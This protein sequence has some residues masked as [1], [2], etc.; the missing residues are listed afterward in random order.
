MMLLNPTG[1]YLAVAGAGHVIVLELPQEYNM[2]TF[3]SLK[4]IKIGREPWYSG[5][6]AVRKMEWHPLS[7]DKTHLLILTSDN[8]IR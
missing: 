3:F 4:S 1:R 7:A 8:A 2:S 5:R 6:Y